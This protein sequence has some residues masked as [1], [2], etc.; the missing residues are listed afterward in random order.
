MLE[1]HLKIQ[2]RV[3]LEKLKRKENPAGTRRVQSFKPDEG[4]SEEQQDDDEAI[5]QALGINN[6]EQCFM[7]GAPF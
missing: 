2:C 5:L 4:R 7:P 1:G 6:M 3:N